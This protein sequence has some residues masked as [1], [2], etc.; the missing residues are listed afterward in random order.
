MRENVWCLSFWVW[1]LLPNMMISGSIHFPINNLTLFFFIHSSTDGN[2]CWLHSLAVVNSD[3]VNMVCRCLW[4]WVLNLVKWV[5]GS[6]W[7]YLLYPLPNHRTL[8][9]PNPLLWSFPTLLDPLSQQVAQ[10]LAH[11]PISLLIL[12][13]PKRKPSSLGKI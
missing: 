8:I 10:F 4:P 9:L 1:L 13:L 7:A 6:K 3:A 2:I 12:L 5:N 11:S